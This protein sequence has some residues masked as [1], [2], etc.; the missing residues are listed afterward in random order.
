M[1]MDFSREL[2]RYHDDYVTLLKE[3]Q[4]EMRERRNCNRS[5]IINN[6]DKKLRAQKRDVMECI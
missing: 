3:Q 1:K 2:E 5:R 4:D 6:I